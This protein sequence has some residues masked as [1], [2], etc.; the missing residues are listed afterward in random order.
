MD[1]GLSIPK[2]TGQLKANLSIIAIKCGA[3][4]TVNET[5]LD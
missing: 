5:A 1:D 3:G 4:R 2:H